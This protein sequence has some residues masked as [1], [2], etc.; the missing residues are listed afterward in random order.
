MFDFDDGLPALIKQVKDRIYKW[1]D[2]DNK[3]LQYRFGFYRI[4]FYTNRLED[5]FAVNVWLDSPPRDEYPHAHIFDLSS[6]VL[7]GS[8]KNINWNVKETPSG[9]YRL[10]TPFC[11][12]TVCVDAD[13]NR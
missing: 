5:G 10:I 8:V 13:T 1:S 4:P 6:Y 11:T 2:R 12:E 9:D 7:L 3:I